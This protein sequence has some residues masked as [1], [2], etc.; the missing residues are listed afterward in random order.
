MAGAQA[1][2]MQDESIFTSCN[3]RL[4]EKEGYISLY[5]RSPSFTF[6]Q[7]ST[8]HACTSLTSPQA[9][10][11]TSYAKVALDVAVTTTGL[12]VSVSQASRTVDVLSQL[13]S[14]LTSRL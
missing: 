8:L 10:S 5:L 11:V 9:A 3:T 1:Y 7:R 13:P 4:G 12:A 6:Y 14:V 2:V